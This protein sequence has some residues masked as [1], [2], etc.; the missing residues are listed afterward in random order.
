MINI[1]ING[2]KCKIPKGTTILDIARANCFNIPTLCNKP[3]NSVKE[4]CVNRCGI[5]VVQVELNGGKKLVNSC[6]TEA[7][8][9]MV[10]STL[11]KVVV[12]ERT[13]RVKSLELW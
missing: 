12:D 4:N 11:S 7:L 6:C 2:V 3:I 10:I 9:N 13:R 1:K 5:C 8:D